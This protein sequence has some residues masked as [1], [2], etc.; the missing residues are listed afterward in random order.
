MSRDDGERALRALGGRPCTGRAIYFRATY[1]G[2]VAHL[3]G[4]AMGDGRRLDAR[5]N[6][7]GIRGRIV[8]RIAREDPPTFRARVLGEGGPAF[9]VTAVR[10][11][12]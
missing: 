2:G 9:T 5:F 3:A 4:C 11:G 12:S 10:I 7:N 6:D 1:F 8:Q